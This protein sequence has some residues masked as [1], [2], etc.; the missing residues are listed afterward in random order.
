MT[1]IVA[2]LVVPVSLAVPV[3]MRAIS[4]GGEAKR[5]RWPVSAKRPPASIRSS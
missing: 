2:F 5:N 3:P 4:S 1:A